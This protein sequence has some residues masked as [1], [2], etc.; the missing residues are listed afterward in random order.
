LESEG[1]DVAFVIS[2]LRFEIWDGLV[3]QHSKRGALSFNTIPSSFSTLHSLPAGSRLRIS[4][5]KNNEEVKMK[6]EECRY[7]ASAAA[8][9]S[10]FFSR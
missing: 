3:P 1:L 9:P 2:N 4:A 8:A 10:S 6:K 5:R 7:F